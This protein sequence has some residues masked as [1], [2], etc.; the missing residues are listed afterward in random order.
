M[1][2][3]ALNG[4]IQRSDFWV[5]DFNIGLPL[6]DFG[7]WVI[8]GLTISTAQ[9]S[10]RAA[11]AS[12]PPLLQSCGRFAASAST[13]LRPLRGFRL[14]LLQQVRHKAM[15][16]LKSVRSAYQIPSHCRRHHESARLTA[17]FE[18]LMLSLLL[19]KQDQN[20]ECHCDCFCLP[21]TATTSKLNKPSH[22]SVF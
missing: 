21:I 22:S 2:P 18:L 17:V 12:R 6:Q 13:E 11:A 3:K 19:R 5:A 20:N 10:S 16:S 8:D 1:I 7:L 14:K 4:R 9:E 15:A